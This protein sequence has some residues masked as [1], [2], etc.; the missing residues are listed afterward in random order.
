MIVQNPDRYVHHMYDRYICHIEVLLASNYHTVLL[1]SCMQ[2]VLFT[3]HVTL[4][5]KHR[6]RVT[7]ITWASA[8]PS[9]P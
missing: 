3:M 6:Q 7:V 9:K 1:Y 8:G 5:S 4:A 2:C